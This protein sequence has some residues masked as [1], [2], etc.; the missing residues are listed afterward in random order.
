ML[1][2]KESFMSKI[3]ENCVNLLTVADMNKL[4]S[5]LK[6]VMEGF[7]IEELNI[8]EWNMKD[9]DLIKSFMNS[10]NV[11]GRSP[12]TMERY[13]YIIGRFLKFVNVSTRSINVHH[14]RKWISAE[15]ERGIQD[16][17]L[18]GNRVILSS[19]FNWL[20]KEGLIDKNPIANFGTIKV[21]KKQRKTI[22][23]TDFEKLNQAC[24]TLR[25]RA[26]IHFLHSTGCRVSEMCGLT[27]NMVDLDSLE[28]VVHGKGNKDRIVY[29]DEV[30]GLI[31]KDYLAK[32]KDNSPVLFHAL[33]GKKKLN[34]NGVRAMLKKLCKIANVGHVHPHM[35]RR[36]LATNLS[37]HGM[38]IQE[39]SSL[40]GHEEITTTMRYVNINKDVMKFDYRRYA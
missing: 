11:Q 38:P 29:M 30:T 1:D 27:K 39:V 4:S 14:I 2:A 7:R 12:K 8:S 31:L 5:V 37:R 33:R 24:K 35:F 3:Q 17:T 10:L 22:S 40:L 15:K 16:S 26:I 13:N 6:D 32:R 23:D 25:D 20:F 9:D 34:P 36:T 21:P 19:Y 28:C 18:E